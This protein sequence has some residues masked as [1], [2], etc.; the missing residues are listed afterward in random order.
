MQNTRSRLET[1]LAKL[2]AATPP[3]A[4]RRTAGHTKVDLV[5]LDEET[6]DRLNSSLRE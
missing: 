3:L 1:R 6:Q 5:Y 2:L 4:A